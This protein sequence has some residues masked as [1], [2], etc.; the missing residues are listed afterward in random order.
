MKA[1][2][3]GLRRMKWCK[4]Y[5]HMY[6]NAKPQLFKLLQKSGSGA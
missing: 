2:G 1:M 6:V 5:V 3:K 4:T